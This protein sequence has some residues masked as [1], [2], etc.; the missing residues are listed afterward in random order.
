[1]NNVVPWVLKYSPID[2]DSMIL[3][4]ELKNMFNNMIKNHTLNN[5]SLVGQA[6]IGKSTLAKILVSKLDVDYKFQPCSFDGS[7]DVIKTT[8]KDFC[9]LVP[10]NKFKVIIVD[11]ADQISLQGQKALRNIIVES[12]NSTRFILTANYQDQ[13]IPAIQSRCTPI[14]LEFTP[15]DVMKHCIKILSSENI[16]FS[17]Q[18][19]VDFYNKIICKKF[20]DIRSIMEQL[21]LM[22]LS[23]ELVLLECNTGVVDNEVVNFILTHNSV[24]EIRQYLLQNETLFSSDYVEL[25]KQ[26]FNIYQN[27][28][29][30]MLI[31]SDALWK[32]SY[33]LD[34]E[35]QFTSM[36]IRL[37]E[38]R[39]SKK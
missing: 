25:G 22:S 8:V 33:I 4:S 21:Q 32:M 30:A 38:L 39:K 17:K 1:M 13:I 7:I 19:I 35:I 20:P 6:G 14:K 34:K 5:I 26:L 16:K 29:D 36:L 23:G 12:L 2:I 18:N 9:D 28:L 37:L 3:T 15:K 31:I 10:K 24:T 27:D 11:E